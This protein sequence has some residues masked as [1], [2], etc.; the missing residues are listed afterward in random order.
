MVLPAGHIN[1]PAGGRKRPRGRFFRRSD[2]LPT[3]TAGKKMPG[4]PGKWGLMGGLFGKF[5]QYVV[6][7][8]N[9]V[10]VPFGADDRDQ[11][12]HLRVATQI[13]LGLFILSIQP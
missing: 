9:R 1:T 8:R 13:R 6:G 7:S 2:R 4:E 11:F 12:R 3:R 5:G 10:G